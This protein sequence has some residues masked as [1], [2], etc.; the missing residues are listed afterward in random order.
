MKTL[1]PPSLAAIN[2]YD[3][4]LRWNKIF[5]RD[6]FNAIREN[7]EPNVCNFIII[8]II[9]FLGKARSLFHFG[10]SE[11]VISL[12][13]GN[14]F[15][16]MNFHEILRI[17]ILSEQLADCGLYFVQCLVCNSL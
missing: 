13:T 11:T 10:E 14:D 2:R 5:N 12:L 17:Q 1:A 8:M 7:T 3:I 4:K 16:S 15:W 9:N 6:T